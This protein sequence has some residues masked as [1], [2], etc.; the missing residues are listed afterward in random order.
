MHKILGVLKDLLA[1]LGRLILAEGLK[2]LEEIKETQ[3]EL[4]DRFDRLESKVEGLHSNDSAALECDLSVMDDRICHLIGVCRA[5]GYTT[6]EERRRVGRMHEAYRT[7]GGNHGEENEYAI[8][9]QLPTEEEFK[10]REAHED[11]HSRTF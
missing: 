3:R 9:C 11:E 2:P 4:C 5:K 10:R 8:F 6:A 7:R 1:K